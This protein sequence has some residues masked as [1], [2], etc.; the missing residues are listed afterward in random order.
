MQQ[1][2]RYDRR[3]LQTKD[4]QKYQPCHEDIEHIRHRNQTRGP[5]HNKGNERVVTGR[6]A[7]SDSITT[8]GPTC[9]RPI[10][11]L[12][13]CFAFSGF[14]SLVRAWNVASAVSIFLTVLFTFS[15]AHYKMYKEMLSQDKID[16]DEFWPNRNTPYIVD[17]I[18]LLQCCNKI[19]FDTRREARISIHP[20]MSQATLQ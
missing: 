18:V 2:Q 9:L 16:E 14:N 17:I 1:P 13:F 5:K 6:Q 20:I 3:R 19:I 12:C 4:A 10:T 11:N 8:I 15:S 7:I